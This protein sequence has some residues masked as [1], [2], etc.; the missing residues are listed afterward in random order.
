MDT[1]LVLAASIYKVHSTWT[2]RSIIHVFLDG[3][4]S[5]VEGCKVLLD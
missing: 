5:N 2:F 1:L 3:K 4:K